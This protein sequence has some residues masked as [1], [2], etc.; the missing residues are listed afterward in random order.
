M[1][2]DRLGVM[3]VMVGSV[4]HDGHAYSYFYWRQTSKA[5]VV[6]GIKKD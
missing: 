4:S 1:P 5:I 3:A 6:S 2:P